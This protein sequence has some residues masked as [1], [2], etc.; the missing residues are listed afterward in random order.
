MD[1]NGSNSGSEDDGTLQISQQWDEAEPGGG[2]G[3]PET[4]TV[5]E[6]KDTVQSG[7]KKELEGCKDAEQKLYHVANELLQT[8]R[9]Y[10]ARLHLLDQVG[11]V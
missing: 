11:I 1:A 6:Q 5:T 8:E 2:Q 7:D 9:A 3:S 10:V 4:D